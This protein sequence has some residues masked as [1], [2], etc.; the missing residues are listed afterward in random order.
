[1]T[2]LSHRNADRR[3]FCEWVID[4]S[5]GSPDEQHIVGDTPN[6]LRSSHIIDVGILIGHWG[7]FRMSNQVDMH[8][9]LLS[10]R[11]KQIREDT[12]PF[13]VLT[14]DVQLHQRIDDR[15]R[16]ASYG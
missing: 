5:L 12:L 9:R 14:G 11:C 3:R 13:K 15:M 1:M 6:L 10:C 16:H 7:L 2:L 8:A 4:V